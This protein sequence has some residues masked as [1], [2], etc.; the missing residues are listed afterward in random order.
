M[1]AVLQALGTPRRREILRLVWDGERSVGEIRAALPDE[2]SVATVSEHLQV[3]ARAGL[4]ASRSAGRFRYY[5]AEKA[6]LGSLRTW[7]E[8]MWDDALG[9]LALL[10]ELEAARRGPRPRRRRRTPK[11]GRR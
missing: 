4:V 6:G 10:S 5:R 2:V 8:S 9:R 3:L 1:S 11:K 7:L